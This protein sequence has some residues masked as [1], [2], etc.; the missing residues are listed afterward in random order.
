M[1]KWL[2]VAGVLLSPLVLADP[3]L[4]NGGTFEPPVLLDKERLSIEM[5]S[6]MLDATPVTNQE[7]LEFVIEQPQWQRDNIAA[8]FHDGNYLKHWDDNTEFAKGK[9]NE[10]VTYVSWFAARE[11]CSAQGG[12]LPGLNE[13]EYASVKYRQQQNISDD[14]YARNLFAWYSQPHSAKQQTVDPNAEQLMHMH[15]RVNEWVDDYQLLLTN[16]D[17]VDLLSGSCGD[18]ARF[19]SSFSNANYAT[20]FRYQSRSDYAPQ[21]ATSTMG[22]R[23]AYDLENDHE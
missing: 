8:L 12:R 6:F 5:E 21:S 20:F 13:W 7:F 16:G 18:G 22:F 11:Y 15:D 17:D 4:I 19:M 14:D 3:V 10:P 1:V 9:D 23:C 2:G